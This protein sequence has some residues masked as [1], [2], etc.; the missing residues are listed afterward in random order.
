MRVMVRTARGNA[1]GRIVGLELGADDY[2]P[3]P[4]PPRELMAR[5]K[6]VLRRMTAEAAGGPETAGNRLELGPV[7]LDCNPQKLRSGEVSVDLTITE[8]RIIRVFM[9][10]PDQILSRDEI[11]TLAFGDNY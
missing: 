9:S 2:W 5:I 10:R 6:A 11:Q 8:F 7:V 1:T 3:R 4:L